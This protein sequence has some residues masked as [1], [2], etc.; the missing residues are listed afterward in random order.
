MIKLA[1]PGGE[2]RDDAA[3]LLSS[4]GL[5]SGEYT[6]GSRAYRFP[7]A[8]EETEIRVFREKDIPI[9]IALGNYD[10]GIC[11]RVWLE[12]LLTRY[13]QDQV[14]ALRSLGFGQTEVI[15]AAAP[16]TLDRLGPLESWPEV[17]G[18]RIVS[19]Y[20]NLAES[21]ALAARFPRYHVLPV[22]GAAASY[23]PEDAELAVFADADQQARRP[24]LVPVARLASGSAWL[25]A[26]RASLATKNLSPI[27]GPLLGAPVQPDASLPPSLPQFVQR[28]QR[29]RSAWARLR[30]DIRLAVPDGHAQRHTFAALASA[31]LQFEG[32]GEK[33]SV[34]RPQSGIEGMSVKVVRPQDMPQLVALGNFDLAVTGRDWLADHL[35]AFPSSPVCEVADL[36]R[37]RYS[38][39]V[40]VDQRIPGDD[41]A[42]ALR[43]WS[44]GGRTVIRIASEYANLADQFARQHHLGRYQIIPVSGASEGFVPEDCEILLEG[45]ETG[46][47]VA[48]NHLKVI[49]R[50][51]ESTNCLIARSVPPAGRAGALYT[52]LVARLQSSAAVSV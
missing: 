23:P 41:L 10:L 8:G 49:D 31:G 26:N 27:L 25:L 5:H 33:E 21:F 39:S 13:P 7:L 11:N 35:V 18:L 51:F 20:P 6:N 30:S 9:Q 19:E 40:V 45:T 44:A 1:L 15:A 12:E 2:I 43:F 47:S 17:E 3:A 42:S 22:W 4:L 28:L 29:R 52:S 50:L 46:T 34:P 38:I 48:A 24:G 36:R 14:V 37:S 32:Y 16:E